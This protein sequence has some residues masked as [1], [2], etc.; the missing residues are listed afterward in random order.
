MFGDIL[1]K[2]KIYY[3]KKK[4]INGLIFYNDKNYLDLSY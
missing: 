3:P 2:K 1:S 4:Y